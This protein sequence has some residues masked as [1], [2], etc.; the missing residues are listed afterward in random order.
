MAKANR[1]A[2][3]ALVAIE[4][5]RRSTLSALLAS[6]ALINPVTAIAADVCT[7]DPIFPLIE[8]H[9]QARAV[10][11]ASLENEPS[12]RDKAAHDTWEHGTYGPC[13]AETAAT[14]ALLTTAPTTLAGALA[15]LRYI[16]ATDTD[17]EAYIHTDCGDAGSAFGALVGS[18]IVVLAPLVQQ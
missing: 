8:A 1:K 4:L 14:V 3:T 6:V 15:L 11:L 12:F 17:G 2:S 13:D 9:R 10:W 18:L 7:F 16:E 5:T